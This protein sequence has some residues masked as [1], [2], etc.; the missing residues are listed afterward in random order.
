M[1][2]P[3]YNSLVALLPYFRLATNMAHASL[4]RAQKNRD[5][6]LDEA[7]DAIDEAKYNY[8]SEL[9]VLLTIRFEDTEARMTK[10]ERIDALRA[11]LTRCHT[12]P[13]LA[14][15]EHEKPLG[16]A[17]DEL[18]NAQER[19]VRVAILAVDTP[20]RISAMELMRRIHLLFDA[21]RIQYQREG[22]HRNTL[23]ILDQTLHK[24]KEHYDAT[25]NKRELK[26]NL[27]CFARA[28]HTLKQ[29]Q[30]YGRKHLNHPDPQTKTKPKTRGRKKEK[31]KGTVPEHLKTFEAAFETFNEGM[32][33]YWLQVYDEDGGK[34]Q[35]PDIQDFPYTDH[36]EFQRQMGQRALYIITEFELLETLTDT[37][38]S[39]FMSLV[40]KTS[41][42]VFA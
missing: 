26:G 20:R 42:G 4:L 37:L 21:L 18:N 23:T 19:L 14:E 5:E 22:A 7:K 35:D 16:F 27:D 25:L 32:L 41:T 13:A 29:L 2:H 34:I 3:Q 15:K 40:Q 28:E 38:T 12:L 31:P 9:A 39:F 17:Q 1:L 24:I 8:E 30:E 6:A 36:T 11:E 10:S 33:S